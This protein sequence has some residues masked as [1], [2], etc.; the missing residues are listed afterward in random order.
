MCPCALFHLELLAPS[1]EYA[2]C[3]LRLPIAPSIKQRSLAFVKQPPSPHLHN[4]DVCFSCSSLPVDGSPSSQIR[5]LARKVIAARISLRS[6]ALIQNPT[7]P[8]LTSRVASEPHPPTNNT[9][10]T[11]APRTRS[12]TIIAG[13]TSHQPRT[14]S[15]EETPWDTKQLDRDGPSS[16]RFI[17]I[18]HAKLV[19]HV[20]L[21][22]SVP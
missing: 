2:Q 20:V 16:G 15:S 21:T 17:V 14:R 7:S 22:T 18:Q 9:A 4:T 11:S 10:K 1:P 8:E 6:A 12:R 19:V 13:K 3:H 5:Q